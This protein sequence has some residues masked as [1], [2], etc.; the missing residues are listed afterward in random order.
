MRESMSGRRVFW[1]GLVA[2]IGATN[3]SCGSSSSA[4]PPE[5]TT[6]SGTEQ[7]SGEADQSVADVTVDT[8]APVDAGQDTSKPDPPDG[9]PTRQQC[10]SSKF[11][12]LPAAAINTA[13]GE[14][15]YGRLDGILVA[16]VAP[17]SKN[18]CKADQDHVHLQVLMSGGIFD[19]AVNVDDEG[20]TAGAGIFYT[21]VDAAMP[22]GTWSEGYNTYARL[23]YVGNLGLHSA[24]FQKNTTAQLKAKVIAELETANHISIYMT[25]YPDGSGGHLVHY[26]G[27][28]YDGAVVTHPLNAKAH[29][30]TFRFSDKT[31]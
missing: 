20:S 18:T 31:F 29:F 26:N 2:I 23:D 6:D 14:Y 24:S 4:A 10:I 30:L 11:G 16:I 19:V 8:Q 22:G 15:R 17:S 3:A 12:K 27:P 13:T 25:P 7:D 1:L 9:T 21:T 5:E 28:K